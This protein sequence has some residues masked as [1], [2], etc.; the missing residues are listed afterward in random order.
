M[1]LR[2]LT[3][4]MAT[5]LACSVAFCAPTTLA[6]FTLGMDTAG[7]ATDP[8]LGKAFVTNYTSGTLSIIDVETPAVAA[9]IGA[10]K[11]PRR[12]LANAATSRL[13]IV[14]DTTPGTVTVIDSKTF[15]VVATIPVGNRPR[16]LAADFLVKEVYISNSTG[17]SI[18]VIDTGTNTVVA[19]VPV[20]AGPGGVD[21][22][23]KL[24]KIYVTSATANTVSAIDQHTRSVTTIAVG[25]APQFARVAERTGMVYVNNVT[26]NTVSVIDSAT[27]TVIKTLPVGSGTVNNFVNT[28][29]V[30]HRAY[31]PNANDNTLTII[32]TDAVA[33]VATVPVGAMP[34]DAIADG[35][36][37]DVYVV[38]SADNS[39]TIVDARTETVTGTF[40]VGG[41]PWR[42]V[43]LLDR[44]LVLNTNASA[45]DSI[46][47]A[48]KQDTRVD[49]SIATEFYHAGFDHYFHS[50]DQIEA[51]LLV[52][53]V[54]GNAWDRTY[55]F[56]RVWTAPGPG[57]LPVCRFFSATFAPK[58]SHFFTPYSAECSTLQA[59]GVWQYEGTVYGMALPDATGNCAAGTEPLYRVYNNGMGGAPNHRYTPDRAV[60]NQMLAAGWI[61]EGS[62]PDLV[63]AC[64]PSLKGP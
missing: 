41:S 11:N 5:S 16:A 15:A 24:G 12:L 17:N 54:F 37:G 10:G 2:T 18:S 38:N 40:A 1:K 33:V 43:T 45:V 3:L 34:V 61:P 44:L 62:G 4:A 8:A 32:D 36:G 13:Y 59:A 22:N 60:R 35:D 63:F 7:I 57:R 9:T 23:H 55:A 27:D 49:T 29:G 47:V 58:S 26:D 50:A 6:T 39:V 46:T 53:G 64:T 21:V 48:T 19:T 52:D 28:S 51:R 56:W 30:Y 14:N 42:A 31:L 20:G 25:K